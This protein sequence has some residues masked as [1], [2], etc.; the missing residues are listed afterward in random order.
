MFFETQ[1]LCFSYYRA[2]MTLKDVSFSAEKNMKVLILASKEMGKTTILKV[3]S[4][5]E[6]SRF[7]N[8][9]L[10]GKEL[11]QID[12]KDKN[13]SL[14]LSDPVLFENKTIKDNLNFQCEVCE[15]EPL[16]DEQIIKLLQEFDLKTDVSAKAKRLSLF[17]KRKLQIA[18]ALIKKPQILFLDDQF[19]GLNDDEKIQMIEIYK[20]LFKDKN[21]TIFYAI[22]DES[23]IFL[24]K[25]QFKFISDKVLYLNFAAIKEFKTVQE[26]ISSRSSLDVLK[27]S[28]SKSLEKCYIEKEN[29]DFWLCKEEKKLFKFDSKFNDKLG[30]LKLEFGDIEECEMLNLSG[31]SLD[32]LDAKRF[33]KGLSEKSIFIYSNLTGNLIL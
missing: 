25:S 18:R 31:S 28:E 33:N 11:K 1:N 3:L 12:D 29:K 23:F 32:E 9:Y 6:D 8:I 19:E 16:S 4:G 27:F 30:E 10:N 2:P 21:L 26:F 22:G 13:F 17:E 14:V 24:E 20:N 5:F 7:G 15:K